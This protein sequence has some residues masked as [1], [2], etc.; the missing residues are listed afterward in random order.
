MRATLRVAVTGATGTLG[1][2]VVTALRQRGDEVT[3]LSRGTNW[4]AP[5]EGPPPPETLS[6]R[7]AVV[8]LLGEQIAQRWSDAAKA[9]IRNSRVLGTRN[10]VAALRELPEPER[11]KLL[12]SQSGV[13]YYGAR[14]DEPVDEGAPAG[15]DFLADVVVDWEA[16]ARAAEQ[17]GLRVVVTR[18]GVVLS[19]S[20]GALGK[21][22][23]FFKAGIGGPVAGGRQYLPWVHL[24]DVVGAILF[25][26]DTPALS[27]PV[28]L[29]AP[30]PV[31][32]KDFSRTLGRVLRRPAFAPVP[33]LALK[34]LYGEMAFIVTTGQRAV[35]KR[36]LDAGYAFRRPDLEAALRDVTRR[37]TP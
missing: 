9:E 4:P 26:L 13:G 28:N 22:L 35:P 12:V 16:E 8:N 1:S 31:T 2:A 37:R 19:A 36:L 25:A 14:G 34:A 11:P 21:M 27:G 5:A 17:L 15:D 29:T 6:G 23:P 24:D 33:A 3:E 20:G 30:E 18:T 32:N 7:D 10:L